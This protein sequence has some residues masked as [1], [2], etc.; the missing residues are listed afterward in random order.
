VDEFTEVENEA[1]H[2][3]VPVE[4]NLVKMA[5]RNSNVHY[6]FERLQGFGQ[7][8]PRV[9]VDPLVTPQES[10]GG[11]DNPVMEHVLTEFVVDAH[12]LSTRAGLIFLTG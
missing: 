12:E 10:Q 1:V 7:A 9:R 8:L 3:V 5:W 6:L 2:P 11:F 4:L